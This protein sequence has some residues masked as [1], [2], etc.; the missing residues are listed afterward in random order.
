MALDE[1]EEISEHDVAS[2]LEELKRR[3][4]SARG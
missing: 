1:R 3:N 4:V 2:A